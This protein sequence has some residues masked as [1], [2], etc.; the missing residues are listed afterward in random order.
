[1]GTG[2]S[3][4]ALATG[5]GMKRVMGTLSHL[6]VLFPAACLATSIAP[7]AVTGRP[8]RPGETTHADIRCFL[9]GGDEPNDLV[10]GY[11]H[12][13]GRLIDSLFVS[14][15]LVKD[16]KRIFSSKLGTTWYGRAG[17]EHVFH[18]T[19]RRDLVTESY[20]EVSAEKAYLRLDLNTVHF[21]KWPSG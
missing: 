20:I 6:V 14:I 8:G 16:G 15:T 2:R 17:K 7:D 11:L 21:Q 1:M 18:F 9:E 4:V 12:V 3:P 19:I 5:N 13:K 10:R